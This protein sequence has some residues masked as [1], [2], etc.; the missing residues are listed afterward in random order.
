MTARVVVHTIALLFLLSG[1]P[2]CDR[3]DDPADR[4]L[5]IRVARR[6]MPFRPGWVSEFQIPMGPPKAP[7]MVIWEVSE[8]D[9][10]VPAT[11]EQQKAGDDFVKRCFDV[12][13][14]KNW[15]DRSTGM[16][17]GFL[18]PGS[19]SRHHRND[20]YVLDRIQ[21]DPERP[22]YLM[23]YPD[24]NRDGE[25]ALTGFMFLADGRESR[26]HQFAGPLAIWHY[27]KYTNARC[28]AGHGLL[29]T[30]MIDGQ[31]RCSTGGVP[32]NRSPEMVHVWLIDHPRGPFATGMTLPK[33]VLR[34]GL[35]KRRET[36]GF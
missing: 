2:G 24:P 6:Y 23:Y 12:A 30:G 22:E 13:V 16:A 33:A 8:F 20:E 1:T 14:A 18:V 27:H 7:Q 31:G 11:P 5:P 19:D 4:V 25:Q 10:N 35:A 34:A 21:L 3:P 26:G 32:L 17:D 9:P 15:F 28:W 29:S 36:L